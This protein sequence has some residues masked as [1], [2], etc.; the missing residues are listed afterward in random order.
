MTTVLKCT[1]IAVILISHT[2]IYADTIRLRDGSKH[3]GK[4]ERITA[5]HVVYIPDGT[6]SPASIPRKKVQRI[7]YEDGK[8]IDFTILDGKSSA[9]EKISSS[10]NYFV[11]GA[12]FYTPGLLN[13]VAGYYFLNSG[14]HFSGNYMGKREYGA[15][16]NILYKLNETRKFMHAVALVGGFLSYIIDEDTEDCDDCDVEKPIPF[17]ESDQYFG[18]VY[19]LNYQGFFFEIGLSQ[20]VTRTNN[21]M[22]NLQIGYVYRFL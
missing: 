7:I 3:R 9:G 10:R 12:T 4:V 22:L 17:S 5:Q 21:F 19:N 6:R 13:I 2:V 20:I 15:Q 11:L 16:V 1:I 14:I 8:V 18:I